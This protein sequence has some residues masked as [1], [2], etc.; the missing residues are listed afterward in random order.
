VLC[1]EFLL[2]GVGFMPRF[3]DSKAWRPSGQ[4]IKNE[5]PTNDTTSRLTD[6]FR[7]FKGS[8][9]PWV[10]ILRNYFIG[11]GVCLGYIDNFTYFYL[12]TSFFPNTNLYLGYFLVFLILVQQKLIEL[13]LFFN[14]THDTNYTAIGLF[15]RK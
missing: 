1:H 8:I 10:F 14:S 5:T 12:T 15:S 11:C 7:L 6:S 9:G 13:F 3:Y 4:L 2:R